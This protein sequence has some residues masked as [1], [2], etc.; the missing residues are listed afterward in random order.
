MVVNAKKVAA[1]FDDKF[2][3][4]K[5]VKEIGTRYSTKLFQTCPFNQLS[6]RLLTCVIQYKY[7]RRVPLR[8][9]IVRVQSSSK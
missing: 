2:S 8:V 3:N 7:I 1:E 4:V 9:S 6:F 5:A